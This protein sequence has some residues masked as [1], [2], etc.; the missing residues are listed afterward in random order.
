MPTQTKGTSVAVKRFNVALYTQV[1]GKNTLLS[2]RLTGPAPGDAQAAKMLE[3]DRYYEDLPRQYPMTRITDLQRQRGDTVSVDLVH[4]VSGLPVMGDTEVKGR[5]TSITFSSLDIK[6]DQYR[7]PY[8]SG[9]RMAQQRTEHDLRLL[10]KGAVLGLAHRYIDQMKLIHA[11]GARG[12]D[13]SDDWVVPLATHDEFDDIVINAIKAPSYNRHLYAGEATA[14]DEL[15]T[16]CWLKLSDIARLRAINDEAEVPLQPV[17][18]DGDPQA[19]DDPLLVLLVTSRQWHHLKNYTETTGRD[20]QTF[21]QNAQ[22]RGAQNPLFKGDVGMW[23]GI[24]VRKLGRRI[25]FNQGS[26]VTVAT[27]AAA[28]TEGSVTVP[29][30]DA[31]AEQAKDEAVDRA[32][33]LGAQAVAELW[34]KDTR[35]GVPVRFFEGYED[36]DN[37]YVCSLAGT[38]GIAKLAFKTK[39]GTYTDHGIFVMDSY[40]PDPRVKPVL[41]SA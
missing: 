37:R 2:T 18:L 41:A 34:G 19:G 17:V 31:D 9:G 38:G 8:D 29:T 3:D 12:E 4:P 24:L 14:I 7:F 27:S 36:D 21:M 32:I 28:Y 6:I 15:D 20:W 13:E 10:G 39:S 26:D 35:T 22:L 30:F 25:C 33:L 5:R 16:T 11:A 1:L 40:A 23:D